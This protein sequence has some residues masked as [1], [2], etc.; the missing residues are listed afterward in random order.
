MFVHRTDLPANAGA[1]FE[2][3]PVS[4][5]IDRTHRGRRA[6]NIALISHS[7]DRGVAAEKANP[8]KPPLPRIE[9]A[10]PRTLH[11]QL[12]IAKAVHTLTAPNG[13]D[14]QRQRGVEIAAIGQDLEALAR[15]IP[16]AFKEASALVKAELCGAPRK[17]NPDQPRVPG[18]RRTTKAAVDDPE[19]P[20]WPAGAPDRQGGRFR[21]KDG[22]ADAVETRIQYASLEN[23]SAGASPSAMGRSGGTVDTAEQDTQV[24]RNLPNVLHTVLSSVPRDLI[25][26]SQIAEDHPK[27]PVP[28]VDNDGMPVL[29]SLGNRILRPDDL[30]PERYLRAGFANQSLGTDVSGYEQQ[31]AGGGAAAEGVSAAGPL[32]A[33]LLPVSPGG[34]LDAERFDGNY[35]RDYRHYLN[36]MIGVYAAAAGLKQNAVLSTID[37]YA[38]LKS[39]F[40]ADEPLDEVYTHSAKQDVE[41]TKSGYRLYESGRIRLRR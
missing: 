25:R 26:S 29:D 28:F 24:M 7:S 27:H 20:G 37:D 13:D 6:I 40:N 18:R 14:P 17:Y 19:H 2:G 11:A 10:V 35:V 33:A 21:P 34:I 31:I 32:A 16:R 8:M 30:P 23:P 1:L 41:D 39:T 36:I 9:S 4:F 22:Q 12:E 15:E 38:S 5:E 3:R